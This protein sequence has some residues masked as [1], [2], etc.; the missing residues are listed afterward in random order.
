[1]KELRELRLR[2]TD[3]IDIKSSLASLQYLQLTTLSLTSVS[4]LATKDISIFGELIKLETLELGECTGFPDSFA[5]EIL[6]KLINLEKLRLEKCQKN[7]NTS[8]LID[9]VSILPSLNQLELIN[10]DIQPDFDIKISSCTNIRRLL[11]VPTCISQSAT[12]NKMVLQGVSE[13]SKTLSSFIWT[14]TNELLRVTELYA[15]EGHK[16]KS[17][18]IPVLKPVPFDDNEISSKIIS[19]ADIP[20]IEI[21]PLTMIENQLCRAL[22]DTKIKIL[23]LP[24]AATWKQSMADF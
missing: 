8:K 17:D 21:V 18:S 4:A 10:F 1:M 22:P 15:E 9:A 5:Q 24:L 11:L 19:T 23:K 7:C 14:I 13:M 12:T 16:L 20:Q 2:S 3:C 6:P